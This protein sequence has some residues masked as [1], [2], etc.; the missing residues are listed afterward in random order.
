[1]AS[2]ALAGDAPLLHLGVTGRRYRSSAVESTLS[3]TPS[4]QGLRAR[5]RDGRA[6][7][8]IELRWKAEGTGV[9]TVT[10]ADDLSPLRDA[11]A[12]MESQSGAD[13]PLASRVFS[14]ARVMASLAARLG[15]P[16]PSCCEDARGL[17]PAEVDVETSPDAG[18]VPVA[19]VFQQQCTP[20]HQTPEHA[21]PNF[22]HGDAK[23]VN[24]ALA[25]CAPRIFVRVSMW[26]L[27]PDMRDK[28]PMPPAFALR[29]LGTGRGEEGPDAAVIASLRNAAGEMLR[30]ETGRIPS[31]D[32]LL[33]RGYESL[34]PCLPA[35]S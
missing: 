2:L 18:A 14:R 3:L 1:V 34:R 23:R 6:I 17:P 15:L 20:C 31:V 7:E 28:T 4:S 8:D 9:V 12:A 32:E 22:L 5:L 21:P 11:L 10:V 30:A 19:A 26:Q 16:Q 33:A 35:D 29:S 25:A 13:A 24:A 27:K